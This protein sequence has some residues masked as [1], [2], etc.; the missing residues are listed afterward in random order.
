MRSSLKLWVFKFFK[1]KW[2]S[3]SQVRSLW[4]ESFSMIMQKLSFSLGNYLI[5]LTLIDF[6]I[7]TMTV[8]ISYIVPCIRW[9][10]IDMTVCVVGG[11]WDKN[12]W[13]FS[14]PW[15]AI[16]FHTN[17]AS[18]KYS[19]ETVCCS[20]ISIKIS[21]GRFQWEKLGRDD[22]SAIFKTNDSAFNENC[23]PSFV[24]IRR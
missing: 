7:L 20:N 1:F 11:S 9:L 13:I 23:R 2:F 21:D 3:C 10:S 14:F 19:L 16:P 18:G 6:Y 22:S 12:C 17:R 5:I 4:G 8:T 15:L 24:S